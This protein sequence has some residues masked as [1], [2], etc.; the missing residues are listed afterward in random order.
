M[1]WVWGVALFWAGL[2]IG[3]L[4]GLGLAAALRAN[5][6]RPAQRQEPP[7][8]ASDLSRPEDW[9]GDRT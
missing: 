4:L 1:S 7:P 5:D 2:S 8:P 6:E 3:C 9:F